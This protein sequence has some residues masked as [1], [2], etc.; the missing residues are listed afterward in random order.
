MQL[1]TEF[2]MIDLLPGTLVIEEATTQ[3]LTAQ[4]AID[5]IGLS[6]DETWIFKGIGRIIWLSPEYRP[7][8]AAVKDS[9]PCIGSALGHVCWFVDLQA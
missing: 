6:D 1:Y 2:G 8:I 5:G 4:L 9:M 7:S 3:E